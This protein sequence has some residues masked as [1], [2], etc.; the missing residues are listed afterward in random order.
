MVASFKPT[1][2]LQEG[3]LISHNIGP[4]RIRFGNNG[5]FD[6]RMNNGTNQNKTS[7]TGVVVAG[8]RYN[9]LVSWTDNG[10]SGR[11]Y[12]GYYQKDGGAWTAIFTDSVVASTAN[13][14]LSNSLYTTFGVRGGVA[15]QYYKGES[16]LIALYGGVAG[17]FDAASSATLRNNFYS[18]GTTIA[19]ASRDTAYGLPLLEFSGDAT[20]YTNGVNPGSAGAW[21]EIG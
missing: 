3:F 2:T 14:T 19:R 10:A 1:A 20:D 8:S 7:A 12:Q 13:L 15:S 17:T 11:D 21:D 5:D 4:F 16:Y 9:V 6:I 18:G